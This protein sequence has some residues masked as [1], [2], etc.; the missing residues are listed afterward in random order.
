[1]GWPKAVLLGVVV[2]I[3]TLIFRPEEAAL[4]LAAIERITATVVAALPDFGGTP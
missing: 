2:L 4:I 1:M 3:I